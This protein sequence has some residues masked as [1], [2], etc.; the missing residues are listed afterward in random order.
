[1]LPLSPTDAD[2]YT[3]HT[4][5]DGVSTAHPVVDLLSVPKALAPALAA[6]YNAAAC[7]EVFRWSAGEP[8]R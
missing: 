5:D 6:V 4:D 3:T 2:E 1:M 7:N 8:Q